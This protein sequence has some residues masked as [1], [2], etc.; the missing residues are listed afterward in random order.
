MRKIIRKTLYSEKL[1]LIVYT[2]HKNQYK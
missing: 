1:W 2:H